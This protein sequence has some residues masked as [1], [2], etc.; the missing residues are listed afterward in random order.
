[1]DIETATAAPI[2]IEIGGKAREFKR[3]SVEELAH[4]QSKMPGTAV[5][6]WDIVPRNIAVWASSPQGMMVVLP[7]ASGKPWAEVET[8]GAV[9]DLSPAASEVVMRSMFSEEEGATAGK[10]PEGQ[11]LTE[12]G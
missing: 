2:T 9:V 6:R 7:L 8:W 4:V 5:E 11:S 12:T 1:M 10:K 3:L